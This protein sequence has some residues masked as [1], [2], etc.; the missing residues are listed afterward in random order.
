MTNERERPAIEMLEEAVWLLKSLP[1]SVISLYLIGTLP[2]ILTFL[3]FVSDMSSGAF[4]SERAFGASLLVAISWIWMCCWQT[5]FCSRLRE[6][7]AGQTPSPWSVQRV[8]TMAVI[9]SI[10]QPSGLIVLPI[11]SLAL[12]PFPWAYAF[13]QNVA[14]LG[15]GTSSGVRDLF[16]A[17]S[18]QTGF[19]PRQNALILS[20]LSLLAFVI[21]VNISVSIVVGANLLHS[22]FGIETVFTRS[23]HAALNSTF[24]IA[25]ASL[26]YIVVDVVAKTVYTLRCFYGSSLTTGEDIRA[27][28]RFISAAAVLLVCAILAGVPS[29][30]EMVP[31]R[32]VDA[33]IQQVIR[34]PEYSWRVPHQAPKD[35]TALLRFADKIVSGVRSFADTM[36]RW[37]SDVVDWFE[38]ISKQDK[39]ARPDSGLPANA[40]P[41]LL[42]VLLAGV[43]IA[44]GLR[45]YFGYQREKVATVKSMAAAPI[46]LA[47]ESVTAAL[48]PEEDWLRLGRELLAH[49]D[50]PRG[51]RALY[52]AGLANLGQ[53]GLI[54]VSQSKTN[55]EYRHEVARRARSSPN[56]LP[57]F[58]R[59]VEVFERTWY[60]Q[61]PAD[62]A[63]V[64]DLTANLERMKADA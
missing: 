36:K 32:D 60:G 47:D 38:R 53:R 6:E 61:H 64:Q 34:Q 63:A 27:G 19:W 54:T 25:C 39:G 22:I 31:A 24:L 41:M 51:V 18:R 20:L 2:F 44:I 58:T 26:T 40:V 14:A 5:A 35:D 8:A 1:L 9:Q 28:L 13:Y 29:R 15:D 10:F 30:A 33:A 62:D 56:V 21:L 11:A 23:M 4:A 12:V 59:T 46:D 3:F 55:H 7:I 50:I 16:R 48:L 42:T 37:T 45:L 49:G 57:A 17:A 43:V 52:L